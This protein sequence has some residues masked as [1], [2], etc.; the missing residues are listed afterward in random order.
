MFSP[1]RQT[2][3]GGVGGQT[4]TQIASRQVAD[5]QHVTWVTVLWAGR[6]NF[7]AGATVKADIARMVAHIKPNNR[8]VVMSLLNANT[9]DESKGG[10]RYNA[11]IQL[12]KDLA[13][14]YPDNYLDIRTVIVQSYDPSNVKDR[15][16]FSRDVPPASLLRDHIH[17]NGT[18]QTIV[19][20]AVHDFILRK[21]W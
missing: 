20:R 12:N 4:S 9:A 8:F 2:Y 17:L 21:G 14:L 15:E 11:L 19:A 3:N 6:N 13:A 16:H 7:M 10:T 18:G 1:T 5:T